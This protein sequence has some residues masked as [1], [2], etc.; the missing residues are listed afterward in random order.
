LKGQIVGDLAS[1]KGVSKESSLV[2]AYE[3]LNESGIK[4]LFR[5]A[6]LRAAWTALGSGLYLAVYESGRVYLGGGH[7]NPNEST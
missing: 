6:T 4:G 2:V 7:E 5:G 3:V 1:K